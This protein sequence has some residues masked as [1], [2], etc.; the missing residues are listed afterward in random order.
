MAMTSQPLQ[1]GPAKRDPWLFLAAAVLLRAVREAAAG[2]PGALTWL[3][4]EEAALYAEA[5]DLDPGAPSDWL[6]R[7]CPCPGRL[8]WRH[9]MPR[10]AEVIT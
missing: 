10:I 5:L 8:A 3:A 9:T 6:A 4:S 7:G 1:E 2:D